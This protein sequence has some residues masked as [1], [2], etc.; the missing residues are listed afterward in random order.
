M[1][2]RI[3]QIATDYVDGFKHCLQD[4]LI[5]CT[6]LNDSDKVILENFL[7]TYPNLIYLK[8]DFQRRKRVKNVVPIYDRCIAKR[9][10]GE[11]CTRRKKDDLD[12]CGTHSK[13]Q[14][15]GVICDKEDVK[16]VKRISVHTEDIKGIIYHIDDFNNVYSSK[17]ICNNT[18]NP[19]VIA[20]YIRDDKG[21]LHIPDFGI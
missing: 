17:D 19:R 8:T 2:K 5:K 6:S 10:N 14:P 1:E 3:Q 11:R 18:Q 9:A 20:K 13:G 4:T 16:P 15:H 7:N 21:E 12:Y